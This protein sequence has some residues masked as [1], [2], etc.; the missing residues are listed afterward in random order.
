MKPERWSKI[1]S[2]FHK[3]L[4]A[5]EIRRDSV[6]EESCAGDDEL[7]R[8]VES[9]LAHNSDSASFIEKP[10]FASRANTS[11]IRPVTAAAPPRPDLR[12]IAVGHYRIVEEIGFGGMGVVY[13][14]EDTRLGRL[15]A[16]KFLPEHMAA[17]SVTLE[18]FRRE[19]R[20]ASS[21]NH[22]NI[23]TIYD[24]GEQDGQCF[25]AMELL[26]GRTLEMAIGGRPLPLTTFLDLA[27]HIA[28]ALEAMHK[29]AIV[30]RD[31]KPSNIFVTSRGDAKLLDFGL[32]KR[33]RLQGGS[34]VDATTL[35]GSITGRGQL[36]GTIAYMSPEQAQDKDI[37][38]RSDIFSFGAVLYEMGTGRRAFTGE[39]AASVIAE[40]LRGEP[41]SAQVVNSELPAELYHIIRKTLEKDPADRYQTATDLMVDLRR[42]KR[43]QMGSSS[44]EKAEPKTHSFPLGSDWLRGTSRWTV[45]IAAFLLLLMA[46]FM[47]VVA[48][49]P[50]RTLG[51]LNSAQITFS[52]ELKDPP[53]VTDGTRLYFQSQGVPVEMSVKGGSIAPLRASASGMQM[54]DISPDASEMLA[55][56]LDLNNEFSQ[57][58]IWTIPVLGGYR[59]RLGNQIV[60][61]AH[62]SPD[63]RSIVY[64]SL[65]SIYVSDSQGANLRKIWDA[66]SYTAAPYFSPDSRRIRVTV[67]G[68][69]Q[70]SP[71]NLWELNADGSNPHQ[72]ALDW[73]E[74]ADQTQGQWTR[75]GKHFIFMSHREGVN[76]IY[77]LIQP[78]WFEFWKKATA[79]R[80][81]AGQIDVLGATPGRD[82]DGLFMIGKISQGAMQ[83]YDPKLK[84]FVPF[85]DGLAAA[86]FVISPD[87]KWMAYKDYPQRRLWRSRLDGSEKLQLTDSFA[88]I[89]KWSPDSKW[90]AFSDFKE[91]YRVSVDGGTPE[92]L[93][94]EGKSE[95]APAWWPDGKS[96]AFNDF[97]LPGQALGIKVLDLETRKVSIM[98]GSEFFFVPSWSPDG[99]YMVAIAQNPSRMVLYT[100]ASGTWK[101]LKIFKAPWQYWVWA[102]DS[103]SVY[104]AMRDPEPGEQPGMYQLTIADGKWEQAAKFDGLTVNRDV[105]EGFPSMTADGRVAMMRD[106]SVVQIYW[107]KW[108]ASARSE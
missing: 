97:P 70:D 78:P 13:K 5:D 2:I 61:D 75:D 34:A 46:S 3:A 7:R 59:R 31:L 105:L 102:N 50:S 1:E 69:K 108:A 91:I 14:A 84:R 45:A 68:A 74:D 37:D 101:D 72:L 94:A 63:G 43:E 86:D 79:V 53:L 35:S 16:L 23:C 10:A 71:P 15:V 106:T 62:W 90:I 76:N 67:N 11:S 8:E 26:E 96:I 27:L 9:L 87:K 48:T 19:A 30:H 93:T 88:W 17:D 73:P 32:A 56:K 65:N 25:I 36:L 100:A 6:I 66:P 24:V 39:S 40:I 54:L 77:E 51:T 85:L 20:S 28:D 58:S 38:S 42:L 22:P 57:G 33:L 98:P 89:P 95:V 99:K 55:L 49:M 82:S 47:V 41:K 60:Q 92:K 12:G 29:S 103:R 83:V 4:E 81:T 107:A 18:R 64:A 80:L 52:S 44:A 104:F 21:L